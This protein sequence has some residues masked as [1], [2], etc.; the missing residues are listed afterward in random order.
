MATHST[1]TLTRP[2]LDWRAPLRAIGDFLHLLTAAG[3][4]SREIEALQSMSDEQLARR[5]LSRDDI[6]RHAFERFRYW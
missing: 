2:T 5:G 6:V 1:D 3:Q 4:V